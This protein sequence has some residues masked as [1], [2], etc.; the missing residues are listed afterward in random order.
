MKRRFPLPP[1]RKSKDTN[2]KRVRKEIHGSHALLIFQ[3]FRCGE[4]RSAL[5]SFFNSQFQT[6][7]GGSRVY[8]E[9]GAS[10]SFFSSFLSSF[11]SSSSSLSLLIHDSNLLERLGEWRGLKVA[12]G[13][14]WAHYLGGYQDRLLGGPLGL[15]DLC[16]TAPDGVKHKDYRGEVLR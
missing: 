11:S 3:G 5:A 2:A 12:Y 9:G 14:P 16:C 13:P 4:Y 7:I 8:G 15:L 1:E 10:F 6:T